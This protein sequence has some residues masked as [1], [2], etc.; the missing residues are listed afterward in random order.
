[1]ASLFD[2]LEK[3]GV[4][5]LHRLSK[6]G[7]NKEAMTDAIHILTE[8]DRKQMRQVER[9]SA[10]RLAFAGAISAG[11]SV[12]AFYLA[13]P[14]L[15]RS[16]DPDLK[17]MLEFYFWVGGVT[18]IATGIEIFYIY[19]ESIRASEKLATIAGVNIFPD[20][21][22]ESA[23]AYILVRAA[24]ELPNPP[25]TDLGLDHKKETSKWI[26]L[27]A[28]L[29]YKIKVFASNIIARLI[30]RRL[31]G[32]VVAR[33]WLELIAIPITAAWNYAVARVVLKEARVRT[34]GPSLARE[35]VDRLKEDKENLSLQA[36]EA[37]LQAV[38]ANIV[39]TVDPHPNLIVLFRIM[40][41]AFEID[42]LSETEFDSS[43]ALLASLPNLTAME[44]NYVLKVLE[45]ATLIDGR[46][47]RRE[48]RLIQ[49]TAHT[50]GQSFDHDKL[51]KLRKQ[52]LAGK[53][54]LDRL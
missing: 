28:T 30:L 2:M 52:F 54:I 20:G 12:L 6:R 27:L 42:P 3:F 32:R 19:I 21:S 23:T 34:L 29:I 40:A 35:F 13:S 5:Y 17:T 38:G 15:E 51:K 50:T 49:A 22:P 33:V 11:L 53:P 16:P 37:M 8:E 46:M 7:G 41:E 9:A 18:L 39:R 31:L 24:L 14:I 36:K 4:N 48:I 26:I 47:R 44:N 10:W 25:A 43:Q 1:M 45:A